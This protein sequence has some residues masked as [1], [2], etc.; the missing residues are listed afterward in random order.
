MKNVLLIT[1]VVVFSSVFVQSM[2]Q[3]VVKPLPFSQFATNHWVDSVFKSLSEDERIAQLI[4][5]AAFSNRGDDHEREI[6]KLIGEQKIGG[7]VF[8]QGGPV[9]QAKLVNKYQSASKVPLLMAM[10][11]EWGLGMRLDSTINYPYQMTL[12]AI[13]NDSLLYEMGVEVARQLRRTGIQVNFAP[14]VDVNNNPDNPVINF[15][16]FGED[17]HNVTRKSIAYMQGMQDNGVFTTAKHF[18]GHGDTGTDSHY[19]LPLINHSRERIDT[20]ELFPFREIIKAGIGGVMVAHLNI[21]ALD[22]S[23]RPSTLSKSIVTGLLREELGFTGLIVTDAMN[24]RGVTASN[25]PGVVDRDAI[26]AGNDMLE[27]TEDAART[28]AEIRKVIKEGKLNQKEIDDRCRKVLAIKYWAGLAETCSVKVSD[29]SAELNT[30]KARLLNRD[31]LQAAITVLK[32]DKT[33][34]PIRELDQARTASLSFGRNQLT[35]FQKTLGL[36]SQVDHFFIPND[37]T[38]QYLDSVATGLKDYNR[39]IAGIHDD[40]G[41]PFNRITF[42]QPVMDFI[43][44]LAAQEN[45]VVAVFKNPYV[46]DKIKS[47]EEADG[48]VVTY[49]DNDDVEDL[50]AQLIFGGI[51]ASGRLPVRIGNKFPAGAGIDV[52]GGIRFKYTLPE[53][54]GLV[55]DILYQRVDSIVNQALSV[56]AI[57]GCQ[58]LVAKDKKIVMHK[59]YGFHDYSDTVKVKLTDLYDLASVT[60][61]STGLPSLMK[62]YD[63][64]TFKLDASLGD[65]LPKF[66]RSNKADIPMYDILT[67]QARFKP[68]IPFWKN[69][70]RKNGTYKWATIKNDS[71]KRFPIRL[72]DHMYLH[73]GYPDRIVKVIRKSPLEAEKKYV[74]SDFFFILAPR[75]VESMI[76]TDF[77][78]YIQTNFYKPLGATSLTYNPLSRYPKKSIVPTEH[79]YYFRHEPIHGTVHDEGAIMLNG[80][81]GHAGLFANANDLAKLM[82]MYLDKGEYGGKRYIKAETLEEWTRTRFP[83]NNNRRALGFDKPNLKYPGPNS[84]TAK[85]AGSSSF[86]HTGFTGTFTWMDPESGLLYIFLSN[87]VTPTRDN[88]RLYNLNTRTRIQQVLYDSMKE[89][90]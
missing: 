65:Y 81:S 43:S 13:R 39:V 28:V 70:L 23:G 19:A 20:L 52:R 54:A 18:P 42:S 3:Q 78:T 49:Q 27:F 29:I 88:T 73:R 64:G 44:K 46:L 11:A 62:L 67:H 41:R 40:P 21:P 33:I 68:W 37:A 80:M 38:Q 77:Q 51:D 24:M 26:L 15:R 60:K 47:V 57:P 30:P 63:E 75:V 90:N 31:L 14:V 17:K 53:D 22:P 72:N 84:N 10:D 25:P 82:Q 48:L 61:I 50:T 45:I 79:D 35:T 1:C 71:S 36:Y 69:T 16:S 32:N 56:K 58:V 86:G 76:N 4:M 9:R 89:N 74:Y 7:L 55:S 8:F 5:V 6:L 59:A 87:R 34:L 85:D 66:N 83:E 2:A 12:G